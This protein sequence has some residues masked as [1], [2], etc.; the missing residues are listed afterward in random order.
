VGG[1]KRM[2]VGGERMEMRGEQSLDAAADSRE[3]VIVLDAGCVAK[4]DA[5]EINNSIRCERS[6]M[7]YLRFDGTPR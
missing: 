3:R 4:W 6:A 7:A 2:M 1:Q 5:V